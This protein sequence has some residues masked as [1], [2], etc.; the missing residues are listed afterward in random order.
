[1]AERID[2]STPFYPVA[3][4]NDLTI[5]RLVLDW[6]A[7]TIVILLLK[8]GATKEVVYSGPTAVTMMTALNKVNLSTKSLHK[9]ILEQLIAD[10]H[11]AGTISGTPD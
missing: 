1:M 7:Q 2:L 8:S 6:N 5:A 4:V 9:R 3:P 11:L 10:G